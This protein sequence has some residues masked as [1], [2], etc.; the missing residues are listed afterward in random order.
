[1]NA[2]S[3]PSPKINTLG[4]AAARRANA[5]S[6]REKAAEA[7]A[8]VAVPPDPVTNGDESAVPNFA[9]SYS[10]GL[11][12][13]ALGEVDPVAY[14]ALLAAIASGEQSDFEKLPRGLGA[15]L[16]N[17]VAANTFTLMGGD[18]HSFATAPPPA[19]GSAAMAADMVELYWQAPLRD[20]NFSDY[21]TSP[22]VQRAASELAGLST[23]PVDATNI[24]RGPTPGDLAGPYISQFLLKPCP[25]NSGFQSQAVRV[26]A[27]GA[28]YLRDYAG[29][30]LNQSGMLPSQ[31]DAFDPTYRYLRNGRDLAQWAHYDYPQQAFQNAAFIIFDQRPETILNKNV[32]QLAASNPYKTSLLETGF[33]TFGM[34]HVLSMIAYASA[35]ALHAAWVQKWTVHRRLRPDTMG[36]RVHNRLTGAANYPIHASLLNSDA[37]KYTFQQQGSYLLSQSYGEGGP[38]APSYP[39]GHAVVAGAGATLL[40]AFFDENALVPNA[41]TTSADGLTLSPYGDEAL[42]IGNE[43]NKLAFNIAMARNWAGVNYRSDAVSSLL[44]GEEVAIR[45][46]QDGANV[47]TETFPGFQFTRFD[48]SPVTI[49]VG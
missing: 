13:S 18:P 42:T 22:L 47:P 46:L 40:K 49:P 28:D 35:E 25:V 24:F 20:V 2:E 38:L 27:A 4:D 16:L 26:S 48:G 7:Q 44:L 6:M 10:K 21:A 19:F 43:A 14:R 39:G 32:Y 5:L 37:V 8:R 29:W 33:V 45:I 15:K 11:P 31:S 36:G 3:M 17:P 12:H 9:A 41:V 1:M 34:V 23:N 30:N